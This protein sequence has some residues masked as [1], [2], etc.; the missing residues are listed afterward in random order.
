MCWR[1]PLHGQGARHERR[2][3]LHTRVNEYLAERR[4][5]GCELDRMDGALTSFVNFEAKTHH[6]VSLTIDVMVGWAPQD[7][8]CRKYLPLF[9]PTPHLPIYHS[10]HHRHAV[11]AGRFGHQHHCIVARSREPDNNAPLCGSRSGHEGCAWGRMQKLDE[12][13]AVSKRLTHCCSS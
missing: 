6:S 10:P 3:R 2:S 1:F 13:F 9:A 8:R 5:L 11:A 12:R 7:N 4:C